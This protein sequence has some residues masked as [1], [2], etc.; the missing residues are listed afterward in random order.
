MALD[1]THICSKRME[2]GS[3]R[4]V[5]LPVR[6]PCLIA[7]VQMCGNVANEIVVASKSI[8]LTEL[9]RRLLNASKF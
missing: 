7:H 9:G 2:L 1:T 5:V 6:I 3:S 4:H 8:A